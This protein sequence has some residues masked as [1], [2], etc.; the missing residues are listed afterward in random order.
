MNWKDIKL[1]PK[2]GTRILLFDG[3]DMFVAAW[4]EDDLGECWIYGIS[5][6]HGVNDYLTV[7]DAVS[8][9]ELPSEA[10]ENKYGGRYEKR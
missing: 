3:K 7:C 1:A 10:L 6:E 9:M 4:G 5:G 2:D 8:W